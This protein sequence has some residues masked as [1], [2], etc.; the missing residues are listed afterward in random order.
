MP[1]SF[2]NS[3]PVVSTLRRDCERSGGEWK[4]RSMLVLAVHRLAFEASKRAESEARRRDR[5]VSRV[6]NLAHRAVTEASG[7]HLEPTTRI[8]SGFHIIH[9][10]NIRIHPD[11][12][13]GQ[14][15][16]IMHNV[17]IGTNAQDGGSPTIGDRVFIGAGATILGPVRIGDGAT[18]AA[19]SLVLTDA[20]AG[21]TMLGVPARAL[22]PARHQ[23]PQIPNPV[24][25]SPSPSPSQ[26]ERRPA[27]ATAAT[28]TPLAANE[29]SS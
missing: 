18:I 28:V 15:C 9:A 26:D 19:N 21:A 5:W 16:S 3:V 13:F 29:T 7:V 2:F 11:V 23:R 8:G 10:Q 12:I 25:P 1:A 17:T 24:G 6:V 27:A 14:D 4:S 22:P 20:P